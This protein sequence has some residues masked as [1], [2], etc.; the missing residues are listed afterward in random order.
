VNLERLKKTLI[1]YE[2]TGKV[3]KDRLMP[4]KCPAGKLTIGYGRNIEDVGISKAEAEFMLDNDITSSVYLC[5]R[6]FPSFDTLDD[7]RQEVLVNMMFNMGDTA[8]S[9][10]R[11]FKAAVEAKDWERAASEMENSR[12]YKQ[13]GKRGYELKMM[14]LTGS[15]E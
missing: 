4:Y 3:I 1:Q 8:F 6:M 14:M 10:F 5:R 7:V 12:W 9:K 13:I 2:G 15:A 11:K